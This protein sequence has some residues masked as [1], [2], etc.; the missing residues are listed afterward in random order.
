[1]TCPAD[2]VLI[3]LSDGELGERQARAVRAHAEG[4]TRC[5]AELAELKTIAEDLR[6]RVPGAL[7]GKSVETFA[8]EVLAQIDRPRSEPLRPS[9]WSRWTLMIAASLALPLAV[10]AAVRSRQAPADDWTA[11]G[12]PSTGS[13]APLTTRT[14]LRFG[15]VADS[16][17]EPIAEGAKL[18]ADA[19]LA[20]EVGNTEGAPR[21]L[22][23]FMIDAVGD[24]HWIYPVYE[25]GT[26]PPSS[27]ALPV[28][29][30]PR[31]LGSMVRLDHPAP[32]PAR[33]VAI[34]LPRSE[35]IEHVERAPLDRLSR[36][37]LA[38]RYEG[39]LVVV[40]QVEIRQ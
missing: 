24:R 21:F 5:R 16:S 23:A 38:A 33:L 28:T 17:F 35:N 2:D 4:C 1:M 7:G 12:A 14:L 13:A 9:R 39:S 31:V 37:Q 30:G 6:A 36:E 26:A 29:S 40:T 25:P 32:G 22:L 3:A 18:D 11:R 15:R 27:V 10:T 20:A 8:D 19:L 34:V